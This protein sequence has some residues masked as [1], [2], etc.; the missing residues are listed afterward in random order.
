ML[1]EKLK[2]TTLGCLRALSAPSTSFLKFKASFGV[3]RDEGR[4]MVGLG[5]VGTAVKDMKFLRTATANQRGA[6]KTRREIKNIPAVPV[7]PN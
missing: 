1:K 2:S 4:G 7:H 3:E 5:W 6:I